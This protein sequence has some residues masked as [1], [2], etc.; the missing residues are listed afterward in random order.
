MRHGSRRC[1]WSPISAFRRRPS[2]TRRGAR[3][4]RTMSHERTRVT[5]ARETFTLVGVVVAAAA[6]QLLGGE[7]PAALATLSLAF[8]VVL[9]VCAAVTLRGLAAARGVR[10]G[11]GADPAAA[12]TSVRQRR[13]PL[14]ARGVRAVGRRGGDSVHAR[15]LL[16]RRRDR[17]DRPRRRVPRHL[18]CR[19][20]RRPSR[21][22]V[23]RGPHRQ[24]QRMARRHAPRGRRIRMG[25]A[26]RR[27]RRR[28]LRGDLRALGPRAGRRSRAARV[29]PRR[30]HRTRRARRPPRRRQPTS[31]CGTSP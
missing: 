20:R 5:A 7:Q 13:L 4:C 10:A 31:A 17:R 3:S 30:R 14:A 26:A 29:D 23:A 9:A 22:G 8:A 12:R 1:S 24:A 27:R 16:H 6:P 19:R 18:L 25:V 15:A 28:R 11:R 21:L 2:P